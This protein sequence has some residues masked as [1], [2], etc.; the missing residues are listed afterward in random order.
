MINHRSKTAHNWM[1]FFLPLILVATPECRLKGNVGI[2]FFSFF[3]ALGFD[4]A[5]FTL[6]P[7]VLPPG[8]PTPA[9]L[10]LCPLSSL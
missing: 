1:H 3:T 5:D 9:H 6:F 7:P 4:F 2:D 10:S 8:A